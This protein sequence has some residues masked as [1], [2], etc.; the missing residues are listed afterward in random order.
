[1]GARIGQQQADVCD[2]WA[3]RRERHWGSECGH[4]EG[5]RAEDDEPGRHGW[6]ER[7]S[8]RVGVRAEG[9]QRGSEDGQELLRG[10]QVAVGHECAVYGQWGARRKP[11]DG[12]DRWG[13]RGEHVAWCF[14]G[15]GDGQLCQ[16]KQ[17]RIIRIEQRDIARVWC[18]K[19]SAERDS[20]CGQHGV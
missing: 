12:D 20:A 15:V 2:D 16:A 18:G 8:A 9:G 7:D 11:A 17:P 13:Q 14:S 6:D 10:V 4:C 19:R 1:V 3:T 5:E